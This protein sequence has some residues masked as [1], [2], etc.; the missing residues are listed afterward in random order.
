MSKTYIQV[1]IVLWS[2]LSTNSGI[3]RGRLSLELEL[4]TD[5]KLLSLSRVHISRRVTNVVVQAI[6]N[7]L[8]VRSRDTA[9]IVP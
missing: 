3:I 2:I 7:Q 4:L 1:G 8:V 5:S 6:A 9:S